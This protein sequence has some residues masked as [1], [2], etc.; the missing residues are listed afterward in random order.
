MNLRLVNIILYFIGKVLD[1]IIKEIYV[2]F[3]F[4]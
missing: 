2:H 4:D 1:K 3:K